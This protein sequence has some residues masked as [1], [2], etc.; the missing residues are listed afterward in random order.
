MDISYLDRKNFKA[1]DFFKSDLAK[2]HSILNIPTAYNMQL[3][4]DNLKIT[5][6]KIQQIRDLLHKPIFINSG[7]RCKELNNMVGGADASQHIDGQALDFISPA[8]GKP[9]KI[10]KAIKAAEIEVDQC[11]IE[12]DWVHISIK[13]N[14]NRNE[15]ATLINGKFTLL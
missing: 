7:V 3:T 13:K 10:V 6:D 11:L 12:K 14:R 5:A 4:L 15:F 8:F 1:L 9:E 2:K